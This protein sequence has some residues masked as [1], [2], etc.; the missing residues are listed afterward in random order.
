LG[1]KLVDFSQDKEGVTAHFSNGKTRRAG[2]LI[3]ADGIHSKVREKLFGY[4]ALN[5]TGYTAWRGL[6]PAPA[7]PFESGET[8]GKGRRFGLVPLNGKTVYWFA[9]DNRP[10][11]EANDPARRQEELL[12]LFGGWHFPVKELIATTP[13]GDILRNDIYD[14]PPLEKWTVGRVTLLGDAAHA[15]TPNLGQ[16]ACQAI[17]D[18]VVLAGCLSRF[19]EV[20]SALQR[21]EELRRARTTR[22]TRQARQV[23]TVGQLSNPALVWLRN[24]FA[25]LLLPR[26]QDRQLAPIL[27]YEAARVV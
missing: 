15:M 24:R 19:N 20:T 12:G 27:N 14:L 3:G 16:G 26:L 2:L 5:Y 18:A 11:G 7:E 1:A 22:V 23:G 21:Y 13:A 6:A 8:W 10:E 25:R 17:E 9:T 4:R